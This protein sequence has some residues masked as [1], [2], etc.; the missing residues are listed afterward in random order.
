MA[1]ISSPAQRALSNILPLITSESPD[2]YSAHQKA[3]TSASRL[4]KPPA[5]KPANY[6]AAVEVLF[7]SA[8]E[9]LKRGQLG[10]GVDLGS[11]MI[12]VLEL[13]R[14]SVDDVSRGLFTWS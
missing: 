2:Y 9:L 10:S 7:E 14:D 8:K 3:R 5:S 13:S 1:N 4:V 6:G 11:Y 12:E